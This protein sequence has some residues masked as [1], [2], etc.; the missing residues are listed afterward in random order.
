MTII[1]VWMFVITNLHGGEMGFTFNQQSD[2]LKLREAVIADPS[3]EK[4][5]V[6]PCV[7]MKLTQ[8]DR[9]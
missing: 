2:C 4:R 5:S 7:Q 3:Y 8:P 9:A 1:L 6:T